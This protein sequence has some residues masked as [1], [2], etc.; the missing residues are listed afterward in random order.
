[1]FCRA[2]HW[3]VKKCQGQ[4]MQTVEMRIPQYMNGVSQKDR[5][6][7]EYIG[8]SLE[9]ADIKGKMK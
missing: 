9:V 1:M 7:N 3:A 5:I 6:K 2:E 8:R 4:Q